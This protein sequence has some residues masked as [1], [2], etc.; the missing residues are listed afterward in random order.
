M[1]NFPARQYLL[2]EY[3]KYLH[4]P[5]KPIM[6]PP[7]RW[8]KIEEKEQREQE[9]AVREKNPYA[10][11][12]YLKTFKDHSAPVYSVLFSP[13]GK[14]LVSGGADGIIK[15]RNLKNGDRENHTLI[16]HIQAV[17]SLAFSPDGKTLVS[18]SADSTIKL[19]NFNTGHEIQSLIGHVSS[20]ISLVIT[21]DSQTLVSSSADTTIK[22][23]DLSTAQ[24]KINL[25]GHTNSVLSVAISPD[26]QTLV[27]GSADAT[28]KLWDLRTGQEI[29]TL[30]EGGGFVFAVCF[31][32]HEPILITV[33]ENRT[34]KL[35]DL[36]SG[37]V[38]RSIPTS[39]M[40]VSVAISPNGKTLVGATESSPMWVI[41]MWNLDT[42][43]MISSFRGY[44]GPI[45]HQDIV[46]SVAFSPDG[47]TLGSGSKDTTVKLWGVPPPINIE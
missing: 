2:D 7:D 9:Q 44:N 27:S 4:L 11:F 25:I 5:S 22:L 37:E 43:K 8:Q 39:E 47:Q 28:V 20:V 31:H 41:G 3:F 46:Y 10:F 1:R 36:L 19:W 18:G 6:S 23:W 29:R 34:I 35:W 13:D 30:D 45:Y 38:I 16:G 40:V 15:V 26:G 21:P 33:H 32:P 42:G 12:R 17:I 24:V 14:T